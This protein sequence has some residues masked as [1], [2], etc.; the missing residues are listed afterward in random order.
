MRLVDICVVLVETE[1]EIVIAF[2]I[3]FAV[4]LN[5]IF[6]VVSGNL[7]LIPEGTFAVC[8]AGYFC[9]NRALTAARIGKIC[10]SR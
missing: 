9:E 7:V 2:L 3:N 4:R 5:G 1:F 10:L 6:G 8:S